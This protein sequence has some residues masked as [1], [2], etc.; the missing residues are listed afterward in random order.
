SNRSLPRSPPASPRQVH[1]N[2]R[3]WRKELSVSNLP[4]DVRV[5]PDFNGLPPNVVTGLVHLT[6][7]AAA[8]LV[9]VSSLGVVIS[10]IGLVAAHWTHNHQ[11][12]ERSKSGLI[13]SIL[14]VA[15]L[16]L[17][18]AAANYASHLFQ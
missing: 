14:A 13:V 10:L 5:Q 16:Y 17:G 12:G 3:A 4:L 11:L 18:I 2:T 1:A 15:L 8:V 9:L 7:N 6:N